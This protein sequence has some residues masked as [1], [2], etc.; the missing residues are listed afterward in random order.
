MAENFVEDDPGENQAN[1]SEALGVKPIEKAKCGVFAHEESDTGVAV[2]W[3]NREKVEGAE[4]EIQD[5]KYAEESCGE[6]CESR[7]GGGDDLSETGGVWTFENAGKHTASNRNG[8]KNDEREIG[9]GSGE[10]HPGGT[11]RVAAL[12]VG[13]VGSAGPTDHPVGH[14]VGQDG[15]GDEA[16][17]FAANVGQGIE[18]NLAAFEGGW[19]ATDFGHK[20]VG[21]FVTGG[22][23]QEDYVPHDA[24]DEEV[25]SQ[26]AGAKT[27]GWLRNAQARARRVGVSVK[28]APG[29]GLEPR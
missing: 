12:P 1:H 22:G 6:A 15:D 9:S 17:G 11:A 21:A 14:E 25:G 23:K 5:E 27:T 16:D 19:V 29:L 24:E 2:E 26:H 28:M 13:I 18:G 4:K 8:G 20:S 7:R 3:R 10:G